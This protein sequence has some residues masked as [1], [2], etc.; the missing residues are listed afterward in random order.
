MPLYKTIS[1]TPDSKV[2]LWKIE[3]TLE[4]LLHEV[5]LC[6]NSLNR[7]EKMLSEIHKCGFLS[8]RH[9][10][11]HAGYTDFDLKYDAAGRPYLADGKKISITHSHQFTGI[12]ISNS[13]VGIDIEKQRE[14]ILRIANKFTPL[15]E[16][17]TL[18][19][20]DAVIQKLTIVWC[21]KEA[22]YKLYA[23]EGVSFLNH[24]D[25]ADFN[26]EDLQTT[27][28]ISFNGSRTTFNICFFEFEGYTCAYALCCS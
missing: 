25:V 15:K 5:S 26:F 28:D 7:L 23:Q 19:N 6:E 14:K 27:A 11:K 12:I 17:R 24:I 9:L 22:L 8:I 2:Y 1:V 18:A 16:Y 20:D 3:E 13:E 10:L 4:Q 21:A